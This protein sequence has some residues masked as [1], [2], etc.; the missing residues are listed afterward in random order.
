MGR[1]PQGEQPSRK[2]RPAAVSK[3]HSRRVSDSRDAHILEAVIFRVL[4]HTEGQAA[5]RTAR[6]DESRAAT[7]EGKALK[8]ES[9]R[10]F[11]SEI[12]WVGAERS[13]TSKTT[14]SCRKVKGVAQ[15]GTVS[16]VQVAALR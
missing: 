9:P 8:T 5:W 4:R 6:G 2:Q 11:P 10:A 1:E 7:R 13:K 12:R 14:A 15:P 3:P 16:L